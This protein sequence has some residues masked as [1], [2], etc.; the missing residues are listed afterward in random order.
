M[1]SQKLNA[2]HCKEQPRKGML[3]TLRN[4]ASLIFVWLLFSLYHE[5]L[6][7]RSYI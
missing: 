7:A 4:G 1:A 3:C 5:D 2:H 6:V